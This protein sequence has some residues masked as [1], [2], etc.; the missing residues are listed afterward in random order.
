[1]QNRTASIKDIY[2]DP[3]GCIGGGDGSPVVDPTVTPLLI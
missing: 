3:L 1:M 2:I